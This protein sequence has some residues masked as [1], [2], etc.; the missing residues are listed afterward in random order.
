MSDEIYLI[1]SSDENY[2]GMV[3]GGKVCVY[4]CICVYMCMHM[5]VRVYVCMCVIVCMC[6][7]MCVCV[8]VCVCRVCMHVYVEGVISSCNLPICEFSIQYL[9]VENICGYCL[10]SPWL[11]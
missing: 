1:T 8:S 7:Y 3:D 5:C 2:V 10:L 6:A 9:K 11:D 4:V